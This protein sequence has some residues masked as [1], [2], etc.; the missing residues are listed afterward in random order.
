MGHQWLSIFDSKVLFGHKFPLHSLKV[1]IYLKVTIFL[2]NT[3]DILKV[4]S[5]IL[6]SHNQ[7][8]ASISLNV[9]TLFNAIFNVFNKH[10]V[11]PKG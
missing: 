5:S 6:C 8:Y 11:M 7:S 2:H 3:T 1:N 9:R 4:M 10:S